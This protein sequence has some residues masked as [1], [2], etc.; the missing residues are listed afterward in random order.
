MMAKKTNKNSKGKCEI[1]VNHDLILV[2]SNIHQNKRPNQLRNGL[3]KIFYV[4]TNFLL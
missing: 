3:A 4:F 1:I 2:L